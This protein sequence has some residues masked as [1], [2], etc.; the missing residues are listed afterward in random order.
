KPTTP[1]KRRRTGRRPG[2]FL[3]FENGFESLVD[4]LYKQLDEDVVDFTTSVDHIEKKEHGYHI[5]LSNWKVYNAAVVVMATPH[6]TLP[7]IFSQYDFLKTLNKM[8]VTSVPNISL[9]SD[10]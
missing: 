6:R 10:E 3:S 5:L 7:K 2:P 8:P 4:Q 1:E 9:A